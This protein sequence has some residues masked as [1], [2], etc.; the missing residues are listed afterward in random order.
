MV[1]LGIKC[2]RPI[3]ERAAPGAVWIPRR[4]LRVQFWAYLEKVIAEVGLQNFH[5][6]NEVHRGAE[7]REGEGIPG[8]KRGPV[9]WTT[10]MKNSLGCQ[11][12]PS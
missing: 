12:G 1:A 7:N 8:G 11:R 5:R 4:G 3:T 9:M 6:A 2:H 10:M